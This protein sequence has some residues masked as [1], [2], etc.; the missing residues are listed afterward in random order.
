[1]AI[2]T[3]LGLGQEFDILLLMPPG[4][5]AAHA[6]RAGLQVASFVHIVTLARQLFGRFAP[7]RRVMLMTTG[8]RQSLLAILLAA[9][10]GTRLRH[11]HIVHGGASEYLSYG[12]KR[13]LLP[14]RVSFVAVSGFVRQRL[15]AHGVPGTRI[16]MIENFL[17]PQVNIAVRSKP[18][19]ALTRLAVVSRLD[20][21]KHVG[22]LLDALEQTPALRDM[23]TD[24]FGTGWQMSALRE[25]AHEA[26]LAV[27]FA[28]FCNTVPQQLAQADLLVHTCPEEPFGLAILEAM[29]AGVP[30]LVPDTGGPADF[31][32]DGENGFMYRADDAADL[33][34]QLL[35]IRALA[36]ARLQCIVDN[37]SD[38]LRQRFAPAAR[39]DDYRQLLAGKRHEA[40]A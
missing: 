26:S 12:R 5:A 39:I 4:P 7:G 18:F 9:L 6:R 3:L 22:L 8:V 21:I 23:T 19:D 32:R 28:G 40:H 13:L 15:L 11:L 25:R 16:T 34:R 29:R 36:P 33:A 30:V 20:P 24:V 38:T 14:F 1:M 35:A 17:A 10:T 31:I 27:R 37:A 2:A